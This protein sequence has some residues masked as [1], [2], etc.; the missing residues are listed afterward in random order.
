M[1]GSNPGSVSQLHASWL[2]S[3]RA[4]NLSPKTITT[5]LEALD[6]LTAHAGVEDVEQLDK[7]AVEEFLADQAERYKPAAVSVR[8]RALQQWFRWLVDEDGITADPMARMRRPVVPEQPVAVI[9]MDQLRALLRTCQGTAFLDRRDTAIILLF[10]D[11]GMRLSELVNL[12]V[13][14]LDLDLDVAVVLD[15]GRRARS[16]PF[17]R[18]TAQALDRCLRARSRHARRADAALWLG[19]K[20]KG[21]MTANGVAQMI[22]RR[23]RLIGIPHL[24]P[25]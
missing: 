10:F 1:N 6:Q 22:R 19:E 23:G 4:R 13:D 17:G 14:D 8:Y 2:R 9:S 20:S 21:L 24:H 11:T 12:A 15:K 5:Y 16:C 3:M 25:H 18:K 7:R